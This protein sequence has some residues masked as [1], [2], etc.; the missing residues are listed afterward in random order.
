MAPVLIWVMSTISKIAT[1]LLVTSALLL[2]LAAQAAAAAAPAPA[3]FEPASVS[4]PSA[5]TGFVLGEV[6]CGMADCPSVVTTANG[7]RTWTSVTAPPAAFLEPAEQQPQSIS[8][9]IFA[10]STDGWAFGPALWATTNGGA[11]WSA[12]KIG[13]PVIEMAAAGRSAFAVVASCSQSSGTCNHPTDKVE[14]TP[15]GSDS[16]APVAGLTGAGTMGAFFATS[17]STV[18][19][20]LWPTSTAKAWIWRSANGTTW[21]RHSEACFQPSQAID[22]AG[23]AAPTSTTLFELCAGNPGAGQEGKYVEVSTNGGASAHVVGKLPLGGLTDGFAAPTVGDVSVGA[24]SGAT[25]IY[26]SVNGA[27]TWS[28]KTFNDGG[29]GLTDLQ[30]AGARLG[31]VV[32]GRPG[33]GGSDR[34]WLS[35][36]GGNNWSAVNF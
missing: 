7:G 8:E 2:G 10:N 29:A 30:F 14:K 18:F 17:G 27:R 31:A 13:G 20:A 5:T 26:H 33:I 9:V 36:D 12:E 6:P 19:V 21:Q 3:N 1:P 11:S 23:L 25:L 24:A 34:L 22:L 28:A 15:V 35:R 4:F 32:E 16:W